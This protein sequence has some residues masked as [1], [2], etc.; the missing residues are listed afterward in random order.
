MKNIKQPDSDL[1]PKK[2]ALS[3]NLLLSHNQDRDQVLIHD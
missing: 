2:Q 3:Q 1:K